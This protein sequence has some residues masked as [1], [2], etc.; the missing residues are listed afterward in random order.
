MA[1]E[2]RK[3]G[4]DS[5]DAGE[6]KSEALGGGS[7]ILPSMIKNKIKRRSPREAQAREKIR[8]AAQGSG[9]RCGHRKSS[10][11]LAKW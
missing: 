5:D 4:D 7:R 3:R 6:R 10:R 8:E 1:K 11:T 9:A 2:K